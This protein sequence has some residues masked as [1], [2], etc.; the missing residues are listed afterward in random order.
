MGSSSDHPA[1]WAVPRLG[2]GFLDSLRAMQVFIYL[3]IYPTSYG[4]ASYSKCLSSVVLA[5][6][7]QMITY[8]SHIKGCNCL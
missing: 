8:R 5:K 3:F 7:H 1:L 2:L 4:L 6:I